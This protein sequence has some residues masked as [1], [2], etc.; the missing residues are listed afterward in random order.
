MHIILSVI[1]ALGGLI[2]AII[3]LQR[4]GFDI[5][6][7]N[8]FLWHRHSQW[9]KKHDT[10]PIYKLSEP[11][12]VAALLL[13]GVAKCEGEISAEQKRTLIS[14]YEHDFHLTQDQAS[15]QL[16]ASSHLLRDEIYLVDNI[17][18]I[19]EQSGSIFT[20]VQVSSLLSLMQQVAKVECPINLEQQKLIDATQQYFAKIKKSSSTWA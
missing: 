17:N 5:N 15:D 9:R 6:S 11:L 1:T 8:P 20:E 2:W 18:K 4:T 7:L 13:L 14:I 3:A 10:K 16:L 12:D 19:L